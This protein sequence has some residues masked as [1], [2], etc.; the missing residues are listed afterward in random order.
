MCFRVNQLNFLARRPR[1]PA[2]RASAAAIDAL[3]KT[4]P[5]ALEQTLYPDLASRNLLNAWRTCNRFYDMGTPDGLKDAAEYFER[6]H[7][8]KGEA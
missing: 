8:L 7:E 4:V 5:V 2:P 3:P 1:S 6:Q